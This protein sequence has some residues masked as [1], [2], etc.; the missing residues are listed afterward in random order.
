MSKLTCP[1]CCYGEVTPEHCRPGCLFAASCALVRCGRCGFEF[2][3]PSKSF[4]GSRLARLFGK[5]EVP[6]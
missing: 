1:L 5:K 4:V 3:D 6:V 2:P